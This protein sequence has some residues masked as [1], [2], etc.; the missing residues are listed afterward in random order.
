MAE[1]IKIIQ[2]SFT[3]GELSPA[4]YGRVDLAKYRA[5]A[6]TMEN[7]IVQP[8]GGA[9]NRP[10]TKFV[11]ALPE[12]VRF[13]P[14]QFSIFQSYVLCFGDTTLYVIKQGGVVVGPGAAVTSLPSPYAYA[15]VA[16]IRFTQSADTLF[17][18]HPSYP[19]YKLQRFSDVD[20]Q[21]T[22]V[23]FQVDTPSPTGLTANYINGAPVTKTVLSIEY[24]VSAV[25]PNGEESLPSPAVAV[26][27]DFPWF[28]TGTV[29]LAWNQVVG[30]V[31]YKVYKN[32]R[33][34]FGLVGILSS[35]SA[36]L[37]NGTAISG[38]DHA[39]FVAANAFDGNLATAWEAA[40]DGGS[41]MATAYI[42]QDY[43]APV[44]VTGFRINQ[45]NFGTK[46]G[47]P[48]SI[49]IDSSIDNVGWTPQQT[50]SLLQGKSIWQQFLL[51]AAATARYW[52]ILQMSTGDR[53]CVAELQ[54]QSTGVTNTFTDD[55][56]NE[57]NG[58]GPQTTT[59]PFNGPGNYPASVALY[60]Q[61]LFLA[62]TNNKP[63]N[64]WAT[65]TGLFNNMGVS[66]PLKASDALTIALNA[67]GVNQI[68]HM[69][70]LNNLLLFAGDSEWVVGPG[71]N[72]D[73]VTPSSIAANPQGYVGSADVAPIAIGRCVLFIQ[74]EGTAV[75]EMDYSSYFA[76]F[77]SLFADTTEM[78]IFAN[79]LFDGFSILIWAYQQRPYSTIWAVRNDGTLLGFTYNKKQEISAWH[80]HTT[81]GVFLSVAT[82]N[83][84]AGQTELYVLVQRQV[85]G[86]T[87]Y[88]V[89]KMIHR[90]PVE[91]AVFLDCSL[92]YN[93][94]PVKVFAGLEH[95]EGCTVGIIADGSVLAQQ[96]VTGGKITIAEAASVVSVGLPYTAKL[97]TMKMEQEM[98][99]QTIQGRMS[100]VPRLLVRFDASRG[101]FIGPNETDVIE[102]PYRDGEAWNEATQ[103]YTGD[104]LNPIEPDWARKVQ[105]YIE[106]RDPLPMSVLSVVP[107]M[108]VSES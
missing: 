86:A 25:G 94:A 108:V 39:G 47:G 16:L 77:T 15:D 85:N 87:V 45:G 54:F 35:N 55:N 19:P 73:G 7:F 24:Q 53:W 18:T 36:K 72:T 30:A 66:F 21:F 68:K 40:Q 64:I 11:V 74:Q 80:R 61:R 49:R 104:L 8:Q 76:L 99:G 69:L 52:R 65:Q 26:T 10:G 34:Y 95:L 102:L 58:N 4:L 6:A 37:P 63:D 9:I 17:L 59:D 83:E 97:K 60:Q 92:S 20:W 29:E 32:S 46:G 44:T 5:G 14:F 51:T 12:P 89:E 90:I 103:M 79:H 48:T 50:F 31:Q 82:I 107:E 23:T 67:Q 75:R 43:G 105:V 100:V 101:G 2:P 41:A 1:P 57:D 88:Y 3:A 78:S 96:V 93:G 91:S 28:T 27:V 71:Q 22:P 106:Q 56:I 13:I 42:G 33:G 70:P 98:G 81:Q 84:N 62:S 38:G